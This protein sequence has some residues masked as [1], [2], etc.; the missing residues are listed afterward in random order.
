MPG[1]LRRN[2][3]AARAEHRRR[4]AEQRDELPPP[5]RDQARLIKNVCWQSHT[6]QVIGRALIKSLKLRADAMRVNNDCRPML[7]ACNS[8]KAFGVL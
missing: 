7:L 6:P 1:R 2:P 5:S 4:A 8:Q 3:Y